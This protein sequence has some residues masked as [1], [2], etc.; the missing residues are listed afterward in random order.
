MRTTVSWR[1]VALAVGFLALAGVRASQGAPVWAAVFALAGAANAW[2]ALRGDRA[3]GKSVPAVVDADPAEIA[4]ERARCLAAQRRW[5]VLGLG[6]ALLAAGLL[7]LEPPLAVLGAAAA[8]FAVFRARRVRRYAA[9]LPGRPGAD[10]LGDQDGGQDAEPAVPRRAHSEAATGPASTT[11]AITAPTA[12]LGA[13]TTAS[14][15]T[16]TTC[17]SRVR[18]RGPGRVATT[19]GTGSGSSVGAGS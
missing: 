14:P 6:G 11:T 7:L 9:T 10:Q 16:T 8:L 17:T 4:R 2:L 13:R 19:G 3:D 12:A 15:T 5:Q 18:G 1:H